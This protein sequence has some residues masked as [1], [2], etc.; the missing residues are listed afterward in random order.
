MS[1]ALEGQVRCLNAMYQYLEGKPMEKPKVLSMIV[2]V[3]RE[4]IPVR[5]IVRQCRSCGLLCGIEDGTEKT[6]GAKCP[7]CLLD[8]LMVYDPDPGGGRFTGYGYEET[9]KEGE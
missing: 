2:D 8:E 4:A 3:H 6:P 9:K 7:Y 5:L 1:S